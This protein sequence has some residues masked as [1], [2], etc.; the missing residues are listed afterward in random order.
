MAP[1]SKKQV[2]LSWLKEIKYHDNSRRWWLTE[3]F[4]SHFK[5]RKPNIHISTFGF[6]K[7]LKSIIDEGIFPNLRCRDTR[8]QT[9]CRVHEYII[10]RDNEISMNIKSIKARIAPKLKSTDQSK[11]KPKET[12]PLNTSPLSSAQNCH[13]Y[14]AYDTNR[15]QSIATTLFTG[16]PIR[17]NPYVNILPLLQP[18]VNFEQPLISCPDD[19]T[20]ISI[21]SNDGNDA[22]SESDNL[23]YF[24]SVEELFDEEAEKD[25]STIC[26]D[27]YLGL[28]QWDNVMKYIESSKNL[29]FEDN[30]RRNLF[31]S[32]SDSIA[33]KTN[34]ECDGHFKAYLLNI[35]H[36]LNF[37]LFKFKDQLTL[38]K[39][40]IDRE[41]YIAGYKKPVLSPSYF[42]REVWSKFKFTQ[43]NNPSQ[44]PYIFLSNRNKPRQTLVDRLECMFP[45]YLHSLYRYAVK[46]LGADETSTRLSA[47]MN[48]RSKTLYP[49]CPIRN[50]LGITRHHFW[51]FFYKAGGKLKRIQTKPRLTP[52][53]VK[54]R[55]AFAVKWDDILEN[56][57][58]FYCC[59]L[60]EKWFYT[61][62]RR[63]K[64]KILPRAIFE[65]LKDA[66]YIAPKVRSR[67]HPLKVMYLGLVAPPIEG[68]ADGKILL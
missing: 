63:K 49:D 61:S 34:I 65:S 19:T 9:K 10:V 28:E 2:V 37:G 46:A 51:N 42:H 7:I 38:A 14:S 17:Y 35:A 15:L 53:H 24:E 54:N 62:T 58:E 43:R 30:I 11:P 47:F 50:N 52:E 60:D 66:E 1:K 16:P 22:D 6:T 68:I 20:V 59:F 8:S 64:V 23:S 48:C 33:I 13:P 32:E 21:D 26:D 3:K 18:P 44:A 29:P 4:L 27:S 31:T 5:T 40:I 56:N 39:A 57:S 45:Q 55:Y 12:P 25:S 67:R 36:E 41:S